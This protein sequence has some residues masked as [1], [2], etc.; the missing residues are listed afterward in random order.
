M[1]FRLEGHCRPTKFPFVILLVVVV[2]V[3]VVELF[4]NSDKSCVLALSFF[5]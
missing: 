2:V 4:G 5:L 3:V 1:A